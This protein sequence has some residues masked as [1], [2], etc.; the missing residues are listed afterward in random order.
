MSQKGSG[1]GIRD[2]PSRLDRPPSWAARPAMWSSSPT[3]WKAG[4]RSRRLTCRMPT[5]SC[6]M[7]WPLSQSMKPVQSLTAPGPRW[8]L[9][10]RV[11]WRRAR[12]I[13]AIGEALEWAQD[14][15]IQTRK[16]KADRHA[17]NVLPLIQTIKARG[18][19]LRQIASELNERGIEASRGGEWH[20]MT[21]RN[22]PHRAARG[23]TK[24]PCGM[25]HW[26]ACPKI[27]LKL[28]K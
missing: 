25:A 27:L 19:S 16:A 21:V 12:L 10:M 3:C 26:A 7:S 13:P 9:P 18:A 11:A 1:H 8:T 14:R 23:D 17:A 2:L 5:A 4:P 24:Q 22:A 20:A 6:C 28:N 15:S